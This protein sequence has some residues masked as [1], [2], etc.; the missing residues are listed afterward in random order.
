MAIQNPSAYQERVF[1]DFLLGAYKDIKEP[2]DY[3]QKQQPGGQGQL[4]PGQLPT[5]QPSPIAAAS[6]M[7]GARPT[8]SGLPQTPTVG[9]LG[10]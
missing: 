1:K 10:L 4:V 5:A 8:G 6:K 9:K 7:G 3:I 2:D